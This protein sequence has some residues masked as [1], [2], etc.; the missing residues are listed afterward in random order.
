MNE[1]FLS[2]KAI[3]LSSDASALYVCIGQDLDCTVD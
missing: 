2:W 3:G 1:E